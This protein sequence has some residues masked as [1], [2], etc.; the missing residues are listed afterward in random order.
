VFSSEIP[1]L[2]SLCDRVIVMSKNRIFGELIKGSITN[3]Q[4]MAKAA[5]S[6]G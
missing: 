6:A 3:E 1:E 4:V 2:I 5:G